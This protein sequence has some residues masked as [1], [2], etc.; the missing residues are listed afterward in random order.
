MNKSDVKVIL[1]FLLIVVVG[2][3][4]M[5]IS[6]KEGN[7]VEVYYR[8]NI[9]LTMNLD[10]DNEYI[11][12]GDLGEVVIEVKDRKVRVKK[13]NSPRNICSKE[14]YISDSS[15]PL[16]CLPNNIVIKIVSSSEIDGVVYWWRQKILLE[17]EYLLL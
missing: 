17:L 12:D 7:I 11:V 1:I 6:S 15:R 2:F 4:V 13:E 8:D 14:G 3:I 16:I 5:H 9:V 10:V